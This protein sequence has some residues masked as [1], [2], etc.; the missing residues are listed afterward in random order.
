MHAAQPSIFAR[1]GAGGRLRAASVLSTVDTLA[2]RVP[3][4]AKR[5]ESNGHRDLSFAPA[6]S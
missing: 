3:L 6:F 2:A 5:G 4:H 1:H